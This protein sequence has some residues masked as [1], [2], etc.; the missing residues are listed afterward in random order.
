VE[1]GSYHIQRE[2]KAGKTFR[3]SRMLYILEAGKCWRLEI[4]VHLA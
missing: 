1:V 3:I 4:T 2:Q